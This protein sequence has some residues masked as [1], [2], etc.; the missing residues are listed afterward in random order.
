MMVSPPGMIHVWHMSLKDKGKEMTVWFGSCLRQCPWA[1]KGES[2]TRISQGVRNLNR[3]PALPADEVIQSSQ[4]SVVSLKN[5]TIGNVNLSCLSSSKPNSSVGNPQPA[6]VGCIILYIPSFCNVNSMLNE[7]KVYDVRHPS[8]FISI[9]T[10]V[11]IGV[12]SGVR[13]NCATFFDYR[14]CSKICCL[15]LSDSPLRDYC[16]RCLSPRTHF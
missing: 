13:V 5:E 11:D 7:G 10:A 4:T 14:F 12:M 3:D 9:L 1:T 2:K 16:H 8:G 15:E 6:S